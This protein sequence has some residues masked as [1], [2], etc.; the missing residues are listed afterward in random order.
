V[1]IKKKIRLS[2]IMMVLIPI[3][4]TSVVL[5]VCLN[6]SLGSYW[7]T[8]MDMYSDENGMQF[9]QSMIYNYQQE[10]W[11]NNWGQCPEMDGCQAEIRHS[12]EMTHL[13][14]K[15]SGLGYRFMITKDGERIYSNLSEED[16]DAARS[17]AGDTIDYAKMLTASRYE[18]SVIKSTFWHRESIFC[19]T[20]VHPQETDGTMVNYL[21]NGIL[22]YLAGILVL[23]VALTVCINGIL[24]WWISGSILKPLGKLSL[25]TKEIREGNLDTPMQYEKKDEFGQVCRDFDEMRIY[26]QESVQQRLKDEKRRRNLITGISHDLRTPLT[27]IMGYLDGL[28]DGIADTPEKQL[29]YMQ[30]IKTRTGNLV[31]LVDSLSEYSSLD[32]GFWYH[33]ED[34][35][36]KDYVE[37][38]L[39]LV[40]P[41]MENQQ[42]LIE[43]FCGKGSFSV[44]LDREEFKRIFHNLF[45]NTVRYRRKEDSRVLISMKRKLEGNCLE[46]VFQDDG[47]GVPKECLEQI[48]DSFYRVDDSRNSAE[49]GSGIGLAVVKEIIL[50][51]GGTI[52]A[53]NRGGLAV[54]INIPVTDCEREYGKN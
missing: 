10:L 33:M 35:D 5:I 15:L 12:D 9:A 1:T 32:A 2:N 18:V 47:P 8:F 43:Y 50:G 40:R 44:R 30:A 24:S 25:G 26:L 48:F 13:E 46:L 17:V 52:R 28:L 49:K 41:D 34:T 45:S 7:H 4:F 23:F 22:R 29:R 38:Y 20:A 39:E 27:T 36:F 14:N 19:I 42:V 37:K 6:T 3:L 11:E 21:K 51:H 53:E 31:S 16:L 54:I